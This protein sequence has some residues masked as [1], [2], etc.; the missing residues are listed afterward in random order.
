MVHIMVSPQNFGN[1][2]THQKSPFLEVPILG[3]GLSVRSNPHVHKNSNIS[4][5]NK[6]MFMKF[7]TKAD[8]TCI[9]LH[10]IKILACI[11]PK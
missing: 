5:T 2:A 1:S 6:G 7:Q 4:T 3:N 11:S 9:D 8:K 10:I